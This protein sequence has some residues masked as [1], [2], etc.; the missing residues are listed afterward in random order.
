MPPYTVIEPESALVPLPGFLQGAAE[1]ALNSSNP[2]AIGD[3]IV[4]H[5]NDIARAYKK[6]FWDTI[7]PGGQLRFYSWAFNKLKAYARG[8]KRSRRGDYVFRAAPS[9][10][11]TQP[12]ISDYYGLQRASYGATYA[13]PWQSR[14][15]WWRKKFSKKKKRFAPISKKYFF[16]KL[17]RGKSYRLQSHCCRC[18][19]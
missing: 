9:S 12:S 5:R 15:K 8:A 2:A 6:G 4:A 7:G 19:C 1:L 11:S 16:K 17:R 13:R 3:W 14:K 10:V 18:C